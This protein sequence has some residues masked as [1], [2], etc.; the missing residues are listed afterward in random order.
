MNI[1]GRTQYYYPL[2]LSGYQDTPVTRTTISIDIR[3]GFTIDSLKTNFDAQPGL[4]HTMQRDTNT[5]HIDF[6]T[7]NANYSQDLVIS[8][9][10]RGW[11]NTFPLMS[12]SLPETTD[13]GYFMMW[14]PIKPALTE[15]VASDFVFVI[16]AS[17]SMTGT[18]TTLV[19]QTFSEI[20]RLL[21]P[22]DRFKLV[23]FSDS[24]R[25]FPPIPACCSQRRNTC[26]TLWNF[27]IPITARR[28]QRTMR[29]LFGQASSR[30]SDPKRNTV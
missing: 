25:A 3:A 9:S 2:N 26:S 13:D 7:E 22:Y 10:P 14:T 15:T 24:A 30:G 4:V 19:R 17:A 6:G 8:F 11:H 29:R 21:Q 1:T 12:Y 23:L 16:D 5:C 27:W 28:E 20:L 18:R